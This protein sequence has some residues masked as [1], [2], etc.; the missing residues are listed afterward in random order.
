MVIVAFI[1][2]TWFRVSQHGLFLS[3]NAHIFIRKLKEAKNLKNAVPEV[4]D[5]YSGFHT[6]QIRSW[7]GNLYLKKLQ[8]KRTLLKW[9]PLP[10]TDKKMVH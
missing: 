2:R 5:M 4:H 3:M 7:Y 10:G 1:D 6:K 8:S 9:N